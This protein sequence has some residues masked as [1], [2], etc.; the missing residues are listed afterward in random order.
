[1]NA[2]STCLRSGRGLGSSRRVGELLG[3]LFVLLLVPLGACKRAEPM[4]EDGHDHGPDADHSHEPADD[5]S[6]PESELHVEGDRIELPEVVRSNLGLEFA[7]V[8][9]RRV[10]RTRRVPGA[11]EL[12]PRARVEYRMALA[13][14]VELAVDQYERVEPG[15]VLFRYRSPTWQEFL[16]ETILAE[17]DID[18]AEA[19]IGV[20][21]ARA[22]EAQGRVALLEK[23][24]AA[25]AEMD[26]KH[27]ELEVEAAE[28]RA[29]LPGLEAELELA[30]T[31]RLNAERAREHALHR[32]AMAT[33]VPQVELEREV[34]HEGVS[35]PYYQ[36]VE[37]IE[38]RAREA[39]VVEALAV[40]DGAFVEPTTSVLSVVDPT[41]LRFR[42]LGLQA[43]LGLLQ[44]GQAVR[45][46]PS[47]GPG[48]VPSPGLPARLTIGLEAHPLERTLTLIAVPDVLDAAATW[49]RPGVAA[50][51]EL[52]IEGEE[53][54][55]PAVP[56]AAIVRDG[57]AYVLYRRDPEDLDS[58][59]RVEVRM[60]ADDGRWV[61]IP[62]GLAAGDEVVLAGAYELNL[63]NQR[64]G[65]P[66]EGGHFHDDG[67]FHE[68]D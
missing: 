68:G 44:E 66:D 3:C 6:G 37:W 57:L 9:L 21:E 35:T 47:E 8:E 58:V 12:Q 67:T 4:E 1:M 54:A 14:T 38:V 22:T 56:R 13:G 30:R 27:A 43:D 42:A 40:T 33:G 50:F 19:E 11:F 23:R 28:L 25:L 32:A 46:V 18:T 60:G 26:F 24:L 2:K 59:V 36:T 15:Q 29:S 10:E 63:A 20:A 16:H 34:V 41:R 48:V 49:A 31:R 62:A 7:T 5:A 17:Q 61:A 55:V 51:L 64:N 45:I 53:Q 65:G 39:G 52:V